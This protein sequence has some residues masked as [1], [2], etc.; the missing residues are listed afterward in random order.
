MKPIGEKYI[1]G[2]KL[3]LNFM[4]YSLYYSKIHYKL[5]L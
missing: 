5:L 4:R 1:S 3:L 2:I